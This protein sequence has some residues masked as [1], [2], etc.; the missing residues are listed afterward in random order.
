MLNTLAIAIVL[1][2]AA[3]GLHLDAAA[4]YN[5]A[6]NGVS[7]LV[8]QGG[9][10]LAESYPNRGSA[11]VARELAS[12][13]KSF[14]G[15]MAL[16]AQQDGLL[17]LD[18][19]VS[20]TISEWAADDRKSITI[21]QL[22]TLSSGIPG[23]ENALS[24]GRVPSYAE[25]ILV[26]PKFA[27]GVRF[28]YGPN[29]F[30]AFGEVMRRKLAPRKESVQQ[31][32]VRRIFKPLGMEHGFWRQDEDGNVHL[33]SGVRM[34]AREWAKFGTMVLQDGKDVL[35]PGKVKALFEGTRANPSYGLTWWLPSKGGF[36]PTGFRRWQWSSELPDDVSVAAGAGGQRLY[37]VPSQKLIVVRQAPLLRQDT[38]KD[39]DFLLALFV[40]K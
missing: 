35:P 37:V 33:P 5:E 7:F 6:H 25:A 24:S 38:F 4:K 23:G 11:S 16:C 10:T 32:L 21:R 9:R 31:Y 29:P 26:Q 2:P 19:P 13:T 34:T 22:L 36:D 28:Q 18:E 40:G 39:L 1:Q 15:V 17:T 12:G 20:K 8:I 14:S 30:M 27:P 3:V